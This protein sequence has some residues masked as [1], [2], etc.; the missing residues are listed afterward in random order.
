MKKLFYSN[1]LFITLS[2]NAYSDVSSPVSSK[3]MQSLSSINNDSIQLS[4]CE[5]YKKTIEAEL[6]NVKAR[7]KKMEDKI[8]TTEKAS[9]MTFAEFKSK[10]NKGEF[11]SVD[12]FKK[13]INRENWTTLNVNYEVCN[14]Y[15]YDSYEAGEEAGFW[16]KVGQF[17][18]PS[19]NS[20][21]LFKFFSTSNIWWK[22]HERRRSNRV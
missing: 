3:I 14:L 15:S 21:Q 16:E 5:N 13:N 19:L 22:Y 18:T 11:T 4:A 10:V 9:E 8:D 20:V 12:T 17:F 2:L 7:L 6:E 1:L